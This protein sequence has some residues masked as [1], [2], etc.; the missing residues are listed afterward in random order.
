LG[1][2]LF[3][4]GLLQQLGI[5]RL[6]RSFDDEEWALVFG[7]VKSA[8]FIGFMAL[9]LGHPTPSRSRIIEIAGEPLI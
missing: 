8:D 9:N 5:P 7:L 6:S 2:E 4:F 3:S 1:Q